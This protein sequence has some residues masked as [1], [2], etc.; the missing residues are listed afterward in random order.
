[1]PAAGDGVALDSHVDHHVPDGHEVAPFHDA[2]SIGE[3]ERAV[4]ERFDC[5]ACGRENAPD[6]RF[7]TDCGAS[8][9]QTCPTCS[10]TNLPGARFCGSCGSSLEATAGR[11]LPG[12][13]RLATVVF[14]DIAGFTNL[15]KTTDPEDL[16]EL[17]DSC[18]TK[19][20]AIVERYDGFV[21][22]VIG[23]ALMAVFG[24]PIAHGDDPERAVRASLEMQRCAA[25]NVAEFG[26]LALSV[27]VNTGEVYFAP[28]GP[29]ARDTVLGDAVNAAQRLQAAAGAGAVLVGEETRRATERTIAYE[30]VKPV[31]V[32]DT[33]EPIPA[34]RAL[35]IVA[36]P[37]AAPAAA[38]IGRDGE[39]GVL[40]KIW[41]R[42]TGERR[43]HL[44]TVLGPPGIGKTR[45]AAEVALLAEATG[46]AV[47]RGRSL[48]YGQTAGYSALGQQIKKVAGIYDSDPAKA[49]REKLESAAAATLP[50]DTAG[51]VARHLAA[52]TGIAP[53]ETI[54]E[55]HV[56]FLSV[57][58]FVEALAAE[59][60]LV[61]VFEDIHWAD[62]SLLDL[63]EHLASRLREAPVLVLALARPELLQSRPSWGAGL[64]SYTTLPLEPLSKANAREL[65]L[66]LLEERAEAADPEVAARL[67]ETA[68]GNPLFIEEL[69]ATLAEQATGSLEELPTT[70]RGIIAARLDALPGEERDVVLAASVLGKTFWRGVLESLGSGDGRLADLLDSLEARDFIRR[71]PSSRLQGDDEY[72]FK[73]MLTREVA[74]GTLPKAVRRERHAAVARL[75]EEFAGAR[76][77]ASA[78]ILAHHWEQAGE[79]D[80]A[81]EYMI[82][83]AREAGRAWAKSEAVALYSRALE[84]IPEADERRR[85]LRLERASTLVQAGEFTSAIPDLDALIEELDGVELFEALD[86]RFKATFWGL[87]D[88]AGSSRISKQAAR[89]AE[90]LGDD[91]LR[92]LALYKQSA[93]TAM[94]GAVEDALALGREALATWRPGSRPADRAEALEWHSLHHY[95]LGRYEGGVEVAREAI[96]IGKDVYSVFGVVNG[97]ADLGLS[98]TGL[99][100]HEEA[101]D[102]FARGAAQGRELELQPRFTS[103]LMNMWAGALR[104]VY[105]IEEARRLNEEA[106]EVARRLS[107]PGGIVSGRIDLAVLDLLTADVGAAEAVLPELF[108]AAAGT[109]GWHQ[110]LWTTRIGALAAEIELAA[111]RADTAAEAAREAIERAKRYHRLKYVTAARTALGAALV[112]QGQPEVAGDCLRQALAE[113]E[114]LKHPPS[115]WKA[116]AKLAAALYAAGDDAGAEKA[117]RQAR[118]TIDAFAAGLSEERRARFLAAPQLAGVLAVAR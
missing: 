69:A 34:S 22:K 31:Q 36:A 50:A 86:N 95:W 71:E 11:R 55:K 101:F 19:L 78:S 61:L 48:P 40:R 109:K 56:L 111:G 27:G 17:V 28:A 112:E 37:E 102:V 107:F 85:R 89:L 110:W 99:G 67:G 3:N 97:H 58:R 39:L 24:A 25:E 88:A 60:P 81:V 14:A 64:L 18:M 9:L 41:E 98:L 45:L 94:D 49:A 33:E 84:L 87:T 68:E 52:L 20:T 12:E 29:D 16:K 30:P 2:A 53:E 63:I 116:A 65:A 76:I 13:R 115:I 105:D 79:L 1:V 26:G 42:V 114:K 108:E 7:C 93:A 117:S 5:P 59:G 103:R 21:D 74:Y 100:R 43:P 57:R 51:D 46:G 23:D 82:A 62:S 32:K 54:P 113:A 73:H 15:S 35:E 91:E 77:G 106:I 10:A 72:S 118:E 47:V 96:E 104:E 44:V 92:A 8:L 70:V 4:T 38:M 6:Q 80:K 75:I 83:A 66:R 90:E